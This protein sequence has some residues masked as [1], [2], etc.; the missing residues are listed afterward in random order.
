MSLSIS[1]YE[2]TMKLKPVEVSSYQKLYG[3]DIEVEATISLQNDGDEISDRVDLVLYRLLTVKAV[4]ASSGQSLGYRQSVQTMANRRQV[5]LLQITLPAPLPRGAETTVHLCY[6]GPVCGYPECYPYVR[7]HIGFDFSLLRA[8]VLWFPVVSGASYWERPFGYT[9]TISA[10]TTMVIVSE[11]VR[12]ERESSQGTISVRYVSPARRRYPFTIVAAPYNAISVGQGA[13]VYLRGDA[14]PMEAIRHVLSEVEAACGEW[15]GTPP[16]ELLRIAEIPEGYGSEAS[17][18][19]ILQTEDG[20]G[21]GL[22]K[23]DV[24]RHA[25]SAFGHEAIH[26]WHPRPATKDRTRLMDEGLTHY[27]EARLLG[28]SLGPQAFIARMEQYR[29]DFLRG[30]AA[31]AAVSIS[32]SANSDHIDVISRGKGPWV[33]GVLH[34]W[35][36]DDVFYDILRRYAAKFRCCPASWEDFLGVA[37]DRTNHEVD[38]WADDWLRSARAS[39]LMVCYNTVAEVAAEYGK[40]NG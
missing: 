30:G 31:V 14:S 6:D 29:A 36:G 28:R 4:L 15:F 38:R 33:F 32:E 13:E 24:L 9:L 2:I 17:E 26:R 8:D 18:G 3:G 37:Q 22:G 39:E 34:A 40:R 23:E 21:R 16:N 20:F 27:L 10:P 7:D 11:G 25:L 1:N 12:S 35:L 19:L 5:N